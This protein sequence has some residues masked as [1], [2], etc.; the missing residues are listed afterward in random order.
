MRH[1]RLE[2]KRLGPVNHLQQFHHAPPAMH[3]AP[4]NFA[5]GRQSLTVVLG[6]LARLPKCLSDAPGVSGWI[7]GP[8]AGTR[9]RVDPHHSVSPYADVSKLAANRAGLA[10]LS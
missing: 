2:A 5:F 4:A 3:P 9:R 7:G 8:F 6:N 10:H 1:V